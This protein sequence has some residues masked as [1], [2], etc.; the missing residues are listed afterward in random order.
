MRAFDDAGIYVLYVSFRHV[1][2][3][4]YILS[5]TPLTTKID[6]IVD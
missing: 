2:W 6:F 3:I 1:P 5:P 4:G